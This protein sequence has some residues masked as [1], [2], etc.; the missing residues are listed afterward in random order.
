MKFPLFLFSYIGILSTQYFAQT[1]EISI[2]WT[3]GQSK[4]FNGQ[5]LTVP[6]FFNQHIDNAKPLYFF[7][8]KV[9]NANLLV[10]LKEIRSVEASQSDKAYFMSL[11]ITLP[12]RLEIDYG[13]KKE[14][15]QPYFVV[16]CFPFYLEGKTIKKVTNLQFGFSAQATSAYAK[17]FASESVLR[18]GSGRWALPFKK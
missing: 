14:K 6:G 16:S 7:K 5:N 12:S 2:E 3:K 10:E 1:K 11:G 9:S 4:D 13:V 18:Q 17:D 15:H 8:E